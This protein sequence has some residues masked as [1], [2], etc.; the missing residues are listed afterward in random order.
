[1]TFQA[2][3]YVGL[4]LVLL[5]LIPTLVIANAQYD[6]PAF[7]TEE[8]N[9]PSKEREPLISDAAGEAINDDARTSGSSKGGGF[10]GAM[11][12]LFY[13]I[14]RMDSML[15]RL[16]SA[17]FMACAAGY[18]WVLYFSAFMGQDVFKG[19][20]QAVLHSA[21]RSNYDEGVRLGSLALALM[22]V[23]TVAVSFL[24]D[25]VVPLIGYKS[26]WFIGHLYIFVSCA[27][28]LIPAFCT[29]FAAVAFCIVGGVYNGVTTAVVR[30][31]PA[32]PFPLS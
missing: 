16:F 18:P 27:S 10:K 20:P 12:Q 22:G 11:K 1:M 5:G 21:A 29:P 24:C 13:A 3:F 28:A 32:M 9:L 31:V 7:T 23:V 2:S 6:P 8:S 25:P 19:D 15:F 17:W 4:V 26:L 14:I 30:K